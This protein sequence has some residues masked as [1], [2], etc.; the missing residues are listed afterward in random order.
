MPQAA[1]AKGL[2]RKLKRVEQL[3]LKKI[4]N[5]NPKKEKPFKAWMDKIR[6]WGSESFKGCE[7]YFLI[8]KHYFLCEYLVVLIID[9][10]NI[11]SP[12]KI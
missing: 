12:F 2:K 3:T 1:Q 10:K 9:S 4:R 8:P 7:P 11:T 5:L 6:K